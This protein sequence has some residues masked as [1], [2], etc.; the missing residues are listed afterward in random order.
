[1]NY[2]AYEEQI[3]FLV[4][5]NILFHRLSYIGYIHP[6]FYHMIMAI[7]LA[8]AIYTIW[9]NIYLLCDDD[10]I[11]HSHCWCI[12]LCLFGVHYVVLSCNYWGLWPC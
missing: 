4:L 2:F 5:T 9:W 12:V 10:F 1:M 7:Y 11:P 3:I 8:Y 6:N